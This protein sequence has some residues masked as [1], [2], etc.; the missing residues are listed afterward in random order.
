MSSNYTPVSIGIVAENKVRGEKII[1][2]TLI[3]I[4]T[5]VADDLRDGAQTVVSKGLDNNGDGYRV[6]L[7]RGTTV[8]AEWA[9]LTN[10]VTA[11]DVRRGEQVMVY[12]AADSGKYYWE[13]MGRDDNL[14]RL[15]TVV[16][17]F[18]ANPKLEDA[19]PG[20][21]NN[22]VFEISTH[23]KHATFTTSK[24]NGEPAAYTTQYNTGDG[25]VT[26]MDDL[27]NFAYMDS[28][29]RDIHIENGDQSKLSINKTIISVYAKDQINMDTET[30]NLTAKTF[31]IKVT[32][33]NIDATN[34]TTKA[35]AIK[36][37]TKTMD[38]V[39]PTTTLA[40][41]AS[42]T[43]DAGTMTI[44]APTTIT[45]PAVLGAGFSAGAAPGGGPA[46]AIGGAMKVDGPMT[47]PEITTDKATIG[48]GNY[49]AGTFT[50][51]T[52]A[53]ISWTSASGPGLV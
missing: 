40:C 22:Y 14:R 34:I 37:D 2:C 3:E 12:K 38:T 41:S 19:V 52:T 9:G 10:R 6:S 25:I 44:N 32:D 20:P 4:L 35:T 49:G 51:I 36:T 18:S 11:P 50:T 29:N 46:G 1:R 5:N 24:A 31:N 17:A 13:P 48:T 47:V 39:S 7:N 33:M 27:G 42:Y 30:C 15:E 16:W 21:E 26:L 45:M 43:I 53:S 8:P 23:D 28:V